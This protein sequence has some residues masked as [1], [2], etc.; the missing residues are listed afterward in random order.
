M[1]TTP[2]T[3]AGGAVAWIGAQLAEGWR[4]A[5]EPDTGYIGANHSQ[6]GKRSVVRVDPWVPDEV[7]H[8]IAAMLNAPATVSVE[9]VL[10]LAEDLR[11]GGGP[12]HPSTEYLR[13]MRDARKQTA[14]ELEALTRGGK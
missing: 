13:G 4:F 3:P 6:G 11:T 1:T 10:A 7:G 5:Y 9:A 14:D 8:A 2:D 12:V